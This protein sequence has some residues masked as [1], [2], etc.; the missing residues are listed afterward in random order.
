MKILGLINNEA[1][2]NFLINR[3]IPLNLFLLKNEIIS[4]IQKDSNEINLYFSKEECDYFCNKYFCTLDDILN[5]IDDLEVTNVNYIN[6]KL[7]NGKTRCIDN[8]KKYKDNN[9]KELIKNI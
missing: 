8:S 9:E 2:Y 6:I 4:N 7:Y 1:N 5:I 3:F